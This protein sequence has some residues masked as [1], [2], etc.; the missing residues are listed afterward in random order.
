LIA[1]LEALVPLAPLHEPH[2][3]APMKMAMTLN[4]ELPQVACF[5]TAFHRTAP[6]VEQAFALPYSFFDPFQAKLDGVR[7]RNEPAAQYGSSPDSPLEGDGFELR[8]REHRAMAPSHGF[9]ATSH[10]EAVAPRGARLPW[11]DRVPRRSGFREARRRHAVHPSRN[12]VLR[13][14]AGRPLSGREARR[15]AVRPLRKSGRAKT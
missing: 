4:P 11:R 5:D 1:E 7:D 3:L 14:R 10:R 2:N 9:A 6:E 12:A 15:H 13:R 8:V